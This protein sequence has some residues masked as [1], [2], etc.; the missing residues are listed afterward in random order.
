MNNER[1]R[2][3]IFYINSVNDY[4][5]GAALALRRAAQCDTPPRMTHTA[6]RNHFTNADC[7]SRIPLANAKSPSRGLKTVA[8]ATKYRLRLSAS[9]AGVWPGLLEVKV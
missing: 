2:V 8:A 4:L 1:H 6:H 3:L 5:A 9:Q 7:T